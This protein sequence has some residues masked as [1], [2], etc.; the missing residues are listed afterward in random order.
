MQ[1]R[2]Q[3][4]AAQVPE[5]LPDGPEFVTDLGGGIRKALPRRPQ[6]ARQSHDIPQVTVQVERLAGRFE[7]FPHGADAGRSDGLRTGGGRGP[8]RWRRNTAGRQRLRRP[9]LP[10]T[11]EEVFRAPEFGGEQAMPLRR[12]SHRGAVLPDRPRRCIQADLDT[13]NLLPQRLHPQFSRLSRRPETPQ[14]VAERPGTVGGLPIGPNLPSRCAQLR[15]TTLG[16]LQRRAET[17]VDDGA[18]DD[19]NG[20]GRHGFNTL[21]GVRRRRNPPSAL[22][23]SLFVD[24][25]PA[26][27]RPGN[28]PGLFGPGLQFVGPHGQQRG[29]G[30]VEEVGYEGD[31][32]TEFPP[33]RDKKPE[34]TRWSSR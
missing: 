20:E 29:D 27:L 24:L 16:A 8:D 15:E 19:A 5:A 14:R 11:G 7:R 21:P 12:V 9:T 32:P 13:G 2:R 26:V 33:R 6:I 10:E 1:V 30:R 18:D 4:G 22:F 23:P 17:A 28:L 25:P 34:N 31:C 3:R